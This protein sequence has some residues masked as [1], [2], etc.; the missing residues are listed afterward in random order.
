MDGWTV[1]YWMTSRLAQF[2]EATALDVLVSG[3]T[4]RVAALQK[5][6]ADDAAGWHAA[7]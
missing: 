1:A 4:D 2:G 7:A 3:D 5:L 6:A